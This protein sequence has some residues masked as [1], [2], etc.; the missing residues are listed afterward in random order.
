M[1]ERI[2]WTPFTKPPEPGAAVLVCITCAASRPFITYIE[3][4]TKGLED[5]LDLFSQVVGWMPAEII[6]NAPKGYDPKFGDNRLCLCGHPY[7][8]HFDTYEEMAP[9]GCK[10]CGYQT[11]EDAGIEYRRE[12]NP[13]FPEGIIA[14]T[15][16]WDAWY[17]ANKSLFIHSLCSGFKWDGVEVADDAEN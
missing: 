1:Y 15:P 5:S 12:S 14:G 4:Y 6:L 16:E 2:E 3:H 7:Y 17:E 9:V 13:P 10:Y 8:R 11:E